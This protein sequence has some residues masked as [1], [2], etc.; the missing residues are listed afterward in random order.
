MRRKSGLEMSN[1]IS[2]TAD[3]T[4]NLTH[5]ASKSKP[6]E[7]K[8]QLTNKRM[9]PSELVPD[10]ET[11][12]HQTKPRPLLNLAE[13]ISGANS[14]TLSSLAGTKCPLCSKMLS[15]NCNLR[16]HYRTVHLNI[17]PYHCRKCP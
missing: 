10:H 7:T 13:T 8:G 16:R 2:A 11:S 14:K 17:R 12:K 9:M 1:V 3:A 15:Q 6:P 5:G 4:I